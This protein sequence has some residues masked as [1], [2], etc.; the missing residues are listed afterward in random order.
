MNNARVP[1]AWRL[2]FAR[3]QVWLGRW[4]LLRSLS[5]RFSPHRFQPFNFTRADR[6]PWPFAFAR[7]QLPANANILSFG[8]STGEEIISLK[9]YLPSAHIRGQ[10]I[11]PRNVAIARRRVAYLKGVEVLCT[12]GA[13]PEI[14]GSH[15]PRDRC[16][17]DS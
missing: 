7:D 9:A 2:E 15:R 1:P 13:N 17:A 12:A 5:W 6:Y 8:C 10:D 4:P 11:D 16:Y 14:S 3:V